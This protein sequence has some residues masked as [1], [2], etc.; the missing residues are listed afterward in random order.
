MGLAVKTHL[1]H[2]PSVHFLTAGVRM[3]GI[4]RSTT[5][6]GV[7]ETARPSPGQASRT[8]SLTVALPMLDHLEGLA[9]RVGERA[10][11][12]GSGTVRSVSGRRGPFR[13]SAPRYE[14]IRFRDRKLSVDRRQP[15]IA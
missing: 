10:A 7:S 3:V 13:R 6:G 12:L 14:A 8:M 1:P 4:A 2:T 15:R 11:K 9:V 5:Q